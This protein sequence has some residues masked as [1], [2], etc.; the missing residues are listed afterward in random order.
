MT[1]ILNYNPMYKID[2]SRL[3]DFEYTYQETVVGM[4]MPS[5]EIN[6]VVSEGDRTITVLDYKVRLIG[7]DIGMLLQRVCDRLLK[8]LDL[9]GYRINIPLTFF[10]EIN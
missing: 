4:I 10:P 5:I 2:K 3:K 6:I 8:R 9:K 7:T 1:N